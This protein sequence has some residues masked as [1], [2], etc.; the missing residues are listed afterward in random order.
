MSAS[1]NPANAPALEPGARLGKYTVVAQLGHGGMGGVWEVQDEAGNRYA[2]KSPAQ[3]MQTSPELTKRFARE[4]NAVRMLDHP[5]LV[6]AVD[7][8]VE[9]G[10]LFL[11]M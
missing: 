5:N 2:L 3:G 6:S 9:A 10:Y 8:F 7:V 11:V 4:V 1:L